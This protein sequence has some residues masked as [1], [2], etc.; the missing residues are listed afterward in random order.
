MVIKNK[1]VFTEGKAAKMAAPRFI[2][3]ESSSREINGQAQAHETRKEE[4]TPH[5]SVK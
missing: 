4:G 5:I 2:A 1:P 3:A